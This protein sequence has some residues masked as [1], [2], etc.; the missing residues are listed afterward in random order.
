MS[1]IALRKSDIV[2]FESFLKPFPTNKIMGM[3]K[4]FFEAKGMGPDQEIYLENYY[5]VIHHL[6]QFSKEKLR[7][8][9]KRYII[10]GFYDFDNELMKMWVEVERVNSEITIYLGE[11]EIFIYENDY[12]DDYKL[13]ELMSKTYEFFQHIE[14]AVNQWNQMSAEMKPYIKEK[15]PVEQ[16]KEE[17][18]EHF[19]AFSKEEYHYS[20]YPNREDKS[21]NH[22]MQHYQFMSFITMHFSIPMNAWNFG[23]YSLIV[24]QEHIDNELLIFSVFI[25][26][27][28]M[29]AGIKLFDE[30]YDIYAEYLSA[31]DIKGII[32]RFGDKVAGRTAEWNK[33]L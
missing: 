32:E 9:D 10:G 16:F 13:H 15:P 3:I 30:F 28:G 17:C 2:S 22:F 21:Y 5:N 6:H 7:F 20:D 8:G 18:M 1:N 19:I 31:D 33:S 29:K 24:Q 14:R 11:Y 25:R 27:K 26:F 23:P 12:N 4:N